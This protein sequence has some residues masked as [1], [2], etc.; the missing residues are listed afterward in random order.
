[1]PLRASYRPHHLAWLGLV[2]TTG[3]GQNH[4]KGGHSN[5][6][7][8]ST[9]SSKILCMYLNV[10]SWNY[11]SQQSEL[12]REK[13]PTFLMPSLIQVTWKLKWLNVRRHHITHMVSTDRLSNVNFCFIIIVVQVRKCRIKFVG[14]YINNARAQGS[15]SVCVKFPFVC[16]S[17]RHW[18]PYGNS[19][20]TITEHK[21]K[22]IKQ[23][24]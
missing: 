18:F 2:A 14:P 8:K 4:S 15:E 9:V 12:W 19:A 23:A 20:S 17:E 16:C 3:L 21:W 22:C 10:L 5:R 13:V 1:M 11:T 7:R 6:D 24:W